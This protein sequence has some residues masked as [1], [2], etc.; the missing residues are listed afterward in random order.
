M[1]QEAS[2][3][4]E[5]TKAHEANQANEADVFPTSGRK[6]ELGAKKTSGQEKLVRRGRRTQN[7]RPEVRSFFDSLFS[8]PLPDV[9][10]MGP[11]RF[12]NAPIMDPERRK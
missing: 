8:S 2:A 10:K 6:A 1:M 3:T 7:R 5:A 12:Y 4:H 11:N 9:S